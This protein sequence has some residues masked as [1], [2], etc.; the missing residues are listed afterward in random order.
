MSEILLCGAD[1]LGI[2]LTPEQVM[3]FDR[4][5]NALLTVGRLSGVTAIG[6]KVGIEQRHFVESLALAT[7]LLRDGLLSFDAPTRVLDLGTGGGIPGLPLR[8]LLPQLRLTLLDARERKTAFLQETTRSLELDDVEIVAGRAE[9]IARILEYRESFDMVLARAV[10]PLPVLLELS[11]P[12][13][14]V[15]GRLVTPKGSGLSGELRA[16]ERALA[17]LGGELVSHEPLAIP[18]GSGSQRLVIVRKTKSTPERF[19]RRPGI[20]SKRPL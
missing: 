10:A 19:P 9:E 4:Y 18:E 13:L 20:P 7:A 11:L 12:L 3:L 16:S 6:T 8:I 5:A 14:R 15:G 2:E 1:A 17:M